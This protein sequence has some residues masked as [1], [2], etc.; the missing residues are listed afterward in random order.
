M[1]RSCADGHGPTTLLEY[2]KIDIYTILILLDKLTLVCEICAYK[3]IKVIT[4]LRS[5]RY[6]IQAFASPI[7]FS[8]VLK[9]PPCSAIFLGHPIPPFYYL[10]KT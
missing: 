9:L 1:F 3:G 6:L 4:N 8:D 2:V 7:N 10:T 5:S